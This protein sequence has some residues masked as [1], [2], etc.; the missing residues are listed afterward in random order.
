[1]E[2]KFPPERGVESFVV[3]SCFDFCHFYH[4]L[5]R[6][7]V[8]ELEAEPQIFALKIGALIFDVCWD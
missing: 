4:I 1:M 6:M 5:S 7:F 3:R 2:D 8:G